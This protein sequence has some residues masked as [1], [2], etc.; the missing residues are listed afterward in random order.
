MKIFVSFLFVFFLPQ[1]AEYGAEEYGLDA[2]PTLVVCQRSGLGVTCCSGV[3]KREDRSHWGESLAEQYFIE[4]SIRPDGFL[5]KLGT[6]CHHV[7]ASPCGI[8]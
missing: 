4:P 8:F 5:P 1:P 6:K 7:Y 3:L 2:V